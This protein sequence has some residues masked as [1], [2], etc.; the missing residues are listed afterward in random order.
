MPCLFGISA[1]PL[2]LGGGETCVPKSVFSVQQP[3]GNAQKELVP[4]PFCGMPLAFLRRRLTA[5]LRA[6]NLVVLRLP[7]YSWQPARGLPL[8]F[9]P[10][11]EAR[12]HLTGQIEYTHEMRLGSRDSDK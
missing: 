10:N 12:K 4:R 7:V 1:S 8:N 6:V 11:A 9:E 5:P 2:P 3:W